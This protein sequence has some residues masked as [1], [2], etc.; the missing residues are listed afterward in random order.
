MVLLSSNYY[1]PVKIL[2]YIE[3]NCRPQVSR[4]LFESWCDSEKNG[5]IIAGYTIEGTLAH[6][7]LSNPTEI[8]CLDNRIKP[9]RCQI[10]NISFSAHV[11]Y[12]QSKDNYISVYCTD[13]SAL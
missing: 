11:D 13:Y 4:Q 6:D 7:L 2:S 10:E 3:L 1:F 9:R 5:V 12:A 8:K